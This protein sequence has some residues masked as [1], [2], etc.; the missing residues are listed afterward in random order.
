MQRLTAPDPD[1]TPG[2]LRVATLAVP[3]HGLCFAVVEYRNGRLD[4]LTAPFDNPEE[5][6]ACSAWIANEYPR[7]DAEWTTTGLNPIDVV[8]TFRQAS[9]A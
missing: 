6:D 8:A 1:Q 7:L 3:G 2:D 4:V 5:A 9:H